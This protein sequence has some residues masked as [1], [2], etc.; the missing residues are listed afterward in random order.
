MAKLEEEIADLK[1]E[2]AGY[3]KELAEAKTREEKKDLRQLMASRRETLNLLLYQQRAQAGGTLLFVE[4]VFYPLS[5]FCR[6]CES[7]KVL[8]EGC[9]A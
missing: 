4:L 2:L 7:I 6:F 9:S 8:V 3:K 5:W 1:E